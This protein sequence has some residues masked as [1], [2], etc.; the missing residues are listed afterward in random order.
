MEKRKEEGEQ[1]QVRV[2]STVQRMSLEYCRAEETLSES[3]KQ[4]KEGKQ[5]TL[6]IAGQAKREESTFADSTRSSKGDRGSRRFRGE[7][8]GLRGRR[9]PC[10]PEEDEGEAILHGKKCREVHKG[11][12]PLCT[13]YREE[14]NTQEATERCR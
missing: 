14:E 3:K 13:S 9:V 10:G 2:F 11:T 8:S 1:A 4:K 7:L 12:G 5:S 6:Q